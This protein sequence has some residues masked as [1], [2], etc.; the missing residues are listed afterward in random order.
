MVGRSGLGKGDSVIGVYSLCMTIESPIADNPSEKETP[1][2]AIIG[3][4]GITMGLEWGLALVGESRVIGDFGWRRFLLP[5]SK[6]VIVLA[7]VGNLTID[8]E[9]KIIEWNRK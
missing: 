1:P 2:S 4:V 6:S 3:D 5:R 8:E 9:W 7:G